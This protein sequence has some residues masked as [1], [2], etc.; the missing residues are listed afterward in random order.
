[1]VK[2]LCLASNESEVLVIKKLIQNEIY[3]CEELPHYQKWVR[4]S[5]AFYPMVTENCEIDFRLPNPDETGE[6]NVDLVCGAF[7]DYSDEVINM[8]TD[9]RSLGLQ[10]RYGKSDL[11]IWEIIVDI[12]KRYAKVTKGM[13]DDGI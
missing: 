2:I 5:K 11:A 3:A 8:L 1:M 4:S 12:E 9:K 13:F 6:L 10:K 7:T